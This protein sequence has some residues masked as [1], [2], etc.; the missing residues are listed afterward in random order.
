MVATPGGHRSTVLAHRSSPLLMTPPSLTV[1]FQL[2]LTALVARIPNP[3]P[4]PPHHTQPPFRHLPP[5][6]LPN[7]QSR[8]IAVQSFAL[9]FTLLLHPH[10]LI[11]PLPHLA[12]KSASDHCSGPE[13]K[14]NCWYP[15]SSSR[16]TA[17]PA[18]RFPAR[19]AVLLLRA[20]EGVF[21]AHYHRP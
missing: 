12:V 5:T 8:S 7:F 6:C 10:R 20:Q 15:T 1:Q 19:G 14:G 3:L 21:A 18:P 17:P 11:T 16:S 13:R 9:L 2:Y 4:P